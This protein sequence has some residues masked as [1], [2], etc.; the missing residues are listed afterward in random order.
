MFSNEWE[1]IY[2]NKEEINHWPWSD[3]VSYFN[4]YIRKYNKN[5]K[6]LEVGCGTGPNALF[7]SSLKV[8]Y[9][10]IEGSK[11]AVKI[12]KKK[13]PKLKKK[14]YNF[15]FTLIKPFKKKFNLVL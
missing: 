14:I 3:V 2:K 7:F 1:N 13:Y 9:F 12:F 6:V 5:F 10:A 11:E 15:D 4:R 8:N